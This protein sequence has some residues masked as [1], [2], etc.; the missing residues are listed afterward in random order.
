MTGFEYTAAVGMLYEGQRDRGL[1]CIRD[2]RARYDGRKRSPFNEAEC[3]HHY[4][5]AMASWA[6]V[7]ALTG[8]HY[9][10]LAEE[11]QFAARPGRWFWSTGHAWGTV[12]LEEQNPGF[13]VR[14][15][16][17]EGRMRL[18]TFRLPKAGRRHWERT[19]VMTTGDV[20]EFS[21]TFAPEDPV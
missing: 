17:V 8:F 18:R 10:A 14:L 1:E 20:L 19:R 12:T 4:A 7:L 6:A 3:G 16:V 2:I 11:L 15:Q 13:Q 21:T 9:S 5:R